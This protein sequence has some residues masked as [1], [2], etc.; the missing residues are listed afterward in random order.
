MIE[1]DF[2]EH[3]RALIERQRALGIVGTLPRNDGSRRTESKRQLLR[4]I[5]E[6]AAERETAADGVA[7]PERP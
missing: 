6:S 1:M 2:F 3:E 5:A 7:Q 4:A